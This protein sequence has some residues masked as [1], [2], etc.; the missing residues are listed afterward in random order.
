M[1][2]GA[3]DTGIAPES[4]PAAALAVGALGLAAVVGAGVATRRRAQA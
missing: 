2:V 1:P 4:D 3:A